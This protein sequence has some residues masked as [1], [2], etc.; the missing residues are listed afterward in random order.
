MLTVKK[1]NPKQFRNGSSASFLLDG[2][3]KLVTLVILPEFLSISIVIV[4]GIYIILYIHT[5][6]HI[7]AYTHLTHVYTVFPHR[8]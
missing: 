7:Y 4:M 2:G 8:M 1:K 6:I 3:I 5:Q